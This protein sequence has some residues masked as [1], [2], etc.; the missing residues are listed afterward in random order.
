[1]KTLILPEVLL[2]S[3]LGTSTV[4]SEIKSMRFPLKK[5]FR[6]YQSQ[7]NVNQEAS[8]STEGFPERTSSRI[9]VK[10]PLATSQAKDLPGQRK[11]RESLLPDSQRRMKDCPDWQWV[12]QGSAES[13]KG[14]E[15]FIIRIKFQRDEP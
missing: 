8:P 1:M 4:M 13:L 9:Y 14:N 6:D 3:F 12:T 10:Y 5:A 11:G 15:R 7:C 2:A